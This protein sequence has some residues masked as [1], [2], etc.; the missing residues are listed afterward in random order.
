MWAEL[1]INLINQEK[2][3]SPRS[4]TKT[5][6][7]LF[8]SAVAVAAV[9]GTSASAQIVQNGFFQED[10]SSF[11]GY[12]GYGPIDDFTSHGDGATGV[13]GYDIHFYRSASDPNEVE[14]QFAPSGYSASPTTDPRDFAFVQIPETV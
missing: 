1:P 12:A 5:H 13:N 10:D 7:P 9:A 4:Y 8:V 11:S 3:P 6:S 14:T 2:S